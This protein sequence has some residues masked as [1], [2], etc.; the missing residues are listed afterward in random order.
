MGPPGMYGM[1][2]GAAG[3]PPFPGLD[4]FAMPHGKQA[5]CYVLDMS[6]G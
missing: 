2:P 6:D 5:Q 4:G 1:P 3:I